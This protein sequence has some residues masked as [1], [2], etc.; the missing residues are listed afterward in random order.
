MKMG[1]SITLRRRK[2]SSTQ[3]L[4]DNLDKIN[5]K[6][7]KVKDILK[8]QSTPRIKRLSQPEITSLE[9]NEKKG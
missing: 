1:D 4:F 3:T 2:D 5:K 9:G 6:S 7:K 8:M